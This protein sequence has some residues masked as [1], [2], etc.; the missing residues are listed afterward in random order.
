MSAVSKKNTA[1]PMHNVNV[2]KLLHISKT[3]IK[4][5]IILV[6]RP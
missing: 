3:L 1:L 5:N 4:I 6:L 2:S